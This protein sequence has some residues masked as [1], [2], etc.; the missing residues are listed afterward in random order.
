MSFHRSVRP[1]NYVYLYTSWYNIKEVYLVDAVRTPIG[2]YGGTLGTVRQDDLLSAAITGLLARYPA[3]HLPDDV[4][5]GCA[6]QAGEDNQN[7]ARF[8]ALLAGL[9]DSVPGVTVNRLCG[10]GMQ[11]VVDGSLR[12]GSGYGDMIIS[13]GV[14]SMTRA[15]FVLPKSEAPFQRAVTVADTT[16]GWRFTNT[17]FLEKYDALQMGETAEVLAAKYSITRE[18]QDA[19]ALQSHQRYFQAVQQGK[20]REQII[21]VEAKSSGGEVQRKH[22]NDRLQRRSAQSRYD[23]GETGST[24]AGVQSRRHGYGR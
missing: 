10:S 8:S 18:A 1:L 24:Q 19:F 13:G 23:P 14:E 6:N 11:A 5:I 21:P 17:R 15:P 20:Y 3:L 2:K 12:I 22:V 7:I 9:P 4:I 16:F